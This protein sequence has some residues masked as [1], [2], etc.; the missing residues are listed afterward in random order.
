MDRLAPEE[1]F[2][3][4]GLLYHCSEDLHGQ[5]TLVARLCAHT[6]SS[7]AESSRAARRCVCTLQRCLER[8]PPG[9]QQVNII[10]DLVDAGPANYDYRA[11]RELYFI[12]RAHYP[13]R[14]GHLTVI[15]NGATA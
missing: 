5:P 1:E 13:M 14:I 2:G 11:A 6:T 4:D 15:N 3:E 12:L 9:V 8:M 7:E 10:Y